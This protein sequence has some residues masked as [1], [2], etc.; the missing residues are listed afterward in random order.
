MNYMSESPA[1]DRIQVSDLLSR[2]GSARSDSGHSQVTLDFPNATVDDRVA[3]AVRLRA[4]TDG[5][6]A[7]GSGTAVATFTCT[8]CLTTWSDQVEV[9]L[10]AVFRTHPDD[11]DDEYPVEHGGWIGL[12]PAV[13]DAVALELPARPLCSDS[14]LGLCPTCGTDLNDEPCE[15]HGDRLDSPFAVLGSLFSE[16]SVEAVE[17]DGAETSS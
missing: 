6:V 3:F 7:R 13:H 2:P 1:S 17:S 5:V 10:E 9:P 4:L 14:C 12:G 8:R 16:A 11:E 15:G